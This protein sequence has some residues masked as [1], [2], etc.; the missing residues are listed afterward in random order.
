MTATAS[1]ALY[2][3]CAFARVAGEADL[4]M[5]IEIDET[6]RGR[7]VATSP[8]RPPTPFNLG[9]S[10]ILEH[11]WGEIPA[12]ATNFRLPT[13]V[14]HAVDEPAAFVLFVPAG[15][16]KDSKSGLLLLWAG[17]SV[18]PPLVK[19]VPM[20]ASSVA[21]ALAARRE[22]ARQA[23][24]RDQFHDL[25]ESVPAAILVF[26]GDGHGAII[27]DRAGDLL[28]IKPGQHKAGKLALP[29]RGLRERCDNRDELEI[30]YSAH[31][32]NLN[33]AVTTQWIMGER[34]FEVDTHPIRGSGERGRI[35]LFNDI[36]AELRMAEEL[37]ALAQTDPLTGAPNRRRFEE[38]FAQIMGTSG[39]D[40]RP[41]SVLMID[42]DRFKPIND[43]YGHLVGD[44]VLK[45]I[46]I[47]AR[48]SLRDRDLFAR[49]GGEEFVAMV[50]APSND[51]VKA[52][53]ERLRAAVAS[54]PVQIGDLRIDA[55]ISIGVAQGVK[56]DLP[57]GEFL[58]ALISQA[59]DALYTAK[60]NGRNQ[61]V[62]AGD[63]ES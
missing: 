41:F 2:E 62:I 24:M 4:V 19:H 54:R 21:T 58:A 43:T 38:L 35:W 51:E 55:S 27:N 37:R 25:L 56:G 5:A 17:S 14:V 22:A 47:R 57:A 9:R 63:I 50:S 26:D 30:I 7:P 10:G 23:A 18:P 40:A 1:E 29:M 52:V 46:T 53:A 39:A 3:L 13:A 16:D 6:A 32:G 49:F 33:Y 48:E 8:L 36:T 34:T 31:V 11:A 44:D 45:A 60:Q 28:G 12:S 15:M 59:D 20:L 42:V 61:V